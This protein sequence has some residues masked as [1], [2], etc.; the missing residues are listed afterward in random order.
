MVG[1][2]WG[3]SVRKEGHTATSEVMQTDT[4]DRMA[5]CDGRFVHWVRRR[6]WGPLLA[7]VL[8]FGPGLRGFRQWQRFEYL[9]RSFTPTSTE[10]AG[11]T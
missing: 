10:L 5:C 8:L 4:H 7:G 2:G 6:W 3:P 9:N 11:S 1:V